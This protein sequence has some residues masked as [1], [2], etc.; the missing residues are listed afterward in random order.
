M[1]KTIFEYNKTTDF[2]MAKL[3]SAKQR[4]GI[5]SR[6]AKYISSHSSY[7]SQVI[8]GSTQFTLE[9]GLAITDFF[10]MEPIAKNY[11]MLM[12]QK[13]RAGTVHL[14]NHYQEK[15][16]LLLTEKSKISER[17]KNTTEE[18]PKAAYEKYYSDWYYLAIHILTSIP[19]FHSA[20]IISEHLGIPIIKVEEILQFL[21]RHGFVEQ[22]ENRYQIG[23]R[24]IHIKKNNKLN[25]NH[26]LNWRLKTLE[27]VK[28][29]N[30]QNI[31][32]AV[33]YSLSK[34]DA[35]KLKEECLKF[36]KNNLQI[37]AP[38]KEEVMYC[39]I[40]DFYEI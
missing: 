39:C 10:Q 25:L 28:S 18:I 7:L 32:Y 12:L 31:N 34:K 23:T 6:F 19:Q 40:L 4:R 21:T 9:Q 27:Q 8:K 1:N 29:K 33:V 26:Q 16:D 15:I 24:H 11:F 3:G 37:V 14:Q 20:K 2:I 17:L 5:K 13:E 22:K 36:I 38:S 30:D 35:E